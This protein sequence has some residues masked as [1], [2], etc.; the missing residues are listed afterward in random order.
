ML[1]DT[2]SFSSKG[3]KGTTVVSDVLDRLPSLAP[4][5]TGARTWVAIM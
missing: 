1:P 2:M 5:S 4:S 3:S